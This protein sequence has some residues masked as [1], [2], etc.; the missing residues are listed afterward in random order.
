MQGAKSEKEWS[1][2][3]VERNIQYKQA[4]RDRLAAQ[5]LRADELRLRA[6]E[7]SSSIVMRLVRS[8]ARW[9]RLLASLWHALQQ[10]Q[11]RGRP[12]GTEALC[13]GHY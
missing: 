9:T 11:V 13:P 6:C 10:R 5:K 7:T 4:E 2:G 8:A 12:G 1:R 3:A